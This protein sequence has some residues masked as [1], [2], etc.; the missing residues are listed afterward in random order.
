M[1]I[2]FP[3]LR[4]LLEPSSGFGQ[5]QTILRQFDHKTRGLFAQ[6]NLLN[7]LGI[8]YSVAKCEIHKISGACATCHHL[9]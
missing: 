4:K 7:N 1:E 3:E 9:D 2:T 8:T 5:C 6:S